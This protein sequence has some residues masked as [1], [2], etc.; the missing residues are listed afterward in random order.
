MFIWIFSFERIQYE[1]FRSCPQL[2]GGL[3]KAYCA[4]NVS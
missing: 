2:T 3:A 1:K 4:L